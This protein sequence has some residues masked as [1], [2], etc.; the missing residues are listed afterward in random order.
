MKDNAPGLIV[1]VLPSNAIEATLPNGERLLLKPGTKVLKAKTQG[2]YQSIL[3]VIREW[4]GGEV[5][6]EA[7]FPDGL[8]AKGH[9]FRFDYW[10]PDKKMIVEIDGVSHF[11]D[12]PSNKHTRLRDAEKDAFCQLKG[13]KI[14]RI[15]FADA[16]SPGELIHALN[17]YEENN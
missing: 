5:L 4:A 16:V 8:T 12:I 13:M 1:R 7:S 6:T 2:K 14:M 17:V 3:A 10:I 11:G 15:S 9:P